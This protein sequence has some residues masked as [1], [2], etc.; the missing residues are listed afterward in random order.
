MRYTVQ[1]TLVEDA[2][3]KDSFLKKL[4]SD[5]ESAYAEQ[6]LGV[7]DAY[8]RKMLAGIVAFELRMTGMQCKLKLDQHRIEA[9]LATQAICEN[10]SDAEQDLGH[11]MKRIDN[12]SLN[13]WKD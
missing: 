1:A 10:V 11:C 3:A 7:D 5:H 2:A 9:F 8:A 4:I 6:W 13:C 12:G